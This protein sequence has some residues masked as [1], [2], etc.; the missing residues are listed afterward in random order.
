MR[1]NVGKFVGKCGAKYGWQFWQTDDAV[2]AKRWLKQ[3][4]TGGS[5]DKQ[6]VLQCRQQHSMTPRRRFF[7]QTR[8]KMFKHQSMASIF[9]FFILLSWNILFNVQFSEILSSLKHVDDIIAISNQCNIFKCSIENQ[10]HCQHCHDLPPAYQ[11]GRH[12]DPD[13]QHGCHHHDHPPAYQCGRYH[14]HD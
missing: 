7:W 6:N 12:H 14:D 10:C 2:R 11:Y 1:A 9:Q 5:F 13:H 4:E 8:C 3:R